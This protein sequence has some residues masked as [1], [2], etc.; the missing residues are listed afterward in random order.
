ME[1]VGR[2]A[3][4]APGLRDGRGGQPP[5]PAPPPV[6]DPH[7]S[8]NSWARSRPQ[9][10]SSPPPGSSD[11]G[12]DHPRAASTL[13]RDKV[14]DGRK[15]RG[16]DPGAGGADPCDRVH[17]R[18]AGWTIRYVPLELPAEPG[19]TTDQP[20]RGP[21]RLG[22][23]DVRRL[24]GIGQRAEAARR[25]GTDPIAPE[26]KMRTWIQ[27]PGVRREGERRRERACSTKKEMRCG[28]RLT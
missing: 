25:S 17:G 2:A 9:P 13:D 21:H 16:W 3:A 5:P 27:R 1:W 12:P 6:P 11:L 26:T 15:R 4:A 22:K 18:R 19:L 23:R 20:H 10:P 24:W 7:L 28:W 14:A 8:P